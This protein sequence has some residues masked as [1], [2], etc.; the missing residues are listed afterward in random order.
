VG[1][2]VK[3]D[4]R[5]IA[6]ALALLIS[7]L[8]FSSLATAEVAQKQGVRVTVAGAIAPKRLPRKGS[9]PIAVSVSGRIDSTKPGTEPQLRKFTIQINRAGRLSFKGI[10]SCRIG[11]IDPSTTQQAMAACGPSLIGEGHFSADVR[12]PEQSPFPS[13]GKVLAFAGKVR[14]EHAIFAHIYGTQPV[15]TSY[16]LPF[17]VK[18][19]PGTYG[20]TLEAF[21]PQATGEWGFVSGISLNLNRQ[22]FITAGCPAP[23]G[24]SKVAF[25]MMRTSFG[26]AGGL[27]MSETLNRSCK[28]IG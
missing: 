4:S 16:V 23:K 2:K 28:A 21:L 1:V 24:L 12:L 26:F 5:A 19:T 20:T 3:A 17:L 9:A 10:P 13:E 22:G 14:G 8:L 7:V 15:D 6:V 27:Q 11:R 25:P 18:S